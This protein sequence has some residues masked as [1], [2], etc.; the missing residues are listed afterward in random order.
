MTIEDPVEYQIARHQ[1]DRGQLQER[2]D[3]RAR[4]AHDP[5]LRPGRAARRRDPRR[6]DG[7][8]R[9]PGGDDGPPRADDAAHAQR[10][11]ARSRVSRTWASSRA[12]SRRRSTA[13]SRSASRG[14]SASHCREAVL[15]DAAE[16][17]ELG[18]ERRRTSDRSTAR[19]G[20]ARCAGTGYRGRVALYEVMPCT[21]SLRRLIESARPRRSSPRRRAGNGDA[22]PGRHP[23][24]AR[25][26]SRRSTRSAASPAT[27]CC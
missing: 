11:V 25:R 8:H 19:V 12:C 26:A 22:P 4:A 3:V 23:P 17:E 1:P 16:L 27:G 20:C 15:A 14:G 10:G 9:D 24:R 13:S 7:A 21:G 6:G 5:A 2:P 18:L